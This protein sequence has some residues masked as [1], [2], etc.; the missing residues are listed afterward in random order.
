MGRIS[1]KA[2]KELCIGC[3]ANRYNMGRG[4]RESE[5]DA[6]VTCDACWS[7]SKAKVVNKLVYYSPA[8]IKPR[9]RKRTLSCWHN[10]CGYG[11]IQKSS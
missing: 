1:N 11:E 10:G 2:K 5:I 9:L 4:Y 6:I 3:R 7:L 8:D